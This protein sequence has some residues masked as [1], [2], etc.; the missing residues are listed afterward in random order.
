ML[1]SGNEL[2]GKFL[3]EIFKMNDSRRK[4]SCNATEK[5]LFH[6]Y[7]K[8]R[9]EIGTVSSVLAALLREG[10]LICRYSY[11]FFGMGPVVSKRL[12]EGRPHP[13][14]GDE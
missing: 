2:K 10:R 13:G 7:E 4:N 1:N 3:F 8:Q 5:M 9:P 11:S 14:Y 6:P 12:L